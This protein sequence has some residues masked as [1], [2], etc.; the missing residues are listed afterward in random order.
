MKS[1][2]RTVTKDPKRLNAHYTASQ[3]AWFLFRGGSSL[4]KYLKKRMFLSL[5]GLIT[6]SGYKIFQGNEE[7]IMEDY[8]RTKYKK[9][10]RNVVAYFN[11]APH[12]VLS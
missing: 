5:F 2:S 6:K 1:S 8:I 12:I 10:N 3:C 4:H 11:A 9:N 7:T